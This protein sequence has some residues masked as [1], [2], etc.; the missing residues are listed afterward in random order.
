MSKYARRKDASHSAIVKAFRAL[1]CS[2]VAI[3]SPTAGLPDLAVGCA[4]RTHLVE[5]KPSAA[6]TKDKRQLTP[7]A[8]QIAFAESWKGGGI[9]IVHD[10]AEVAQLTEMWR[11][12]A[13]NADRAA[14]LL[15]R[16]LDE[17]L[18]RING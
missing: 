8:S 3:E 11:L 6:Q 16:E 17:V 9:P 15:K 5:A 13:S 1:G 18:G 7:R 12:E 14:L 10:A 2:A 4:G